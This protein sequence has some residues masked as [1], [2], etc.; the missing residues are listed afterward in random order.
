MRFMPLVTCQFTALQSILES[1]R[2]S[3]DFGDGYA[4]ELPYGSNGPRIRP[5]LSKQTCPEPVSDSDLRVR[6][7]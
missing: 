2:D 5:S 1:L 3:T 4:S 7:T 6:L